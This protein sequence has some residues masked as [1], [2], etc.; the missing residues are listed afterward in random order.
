VLCSVIAI[1][2]FALGWIAFG[3]YI[4]YWAFLIAKHTVAGLR[5]WDEK[6][7]RVI[8][9]TIKP[10]DDVGMKS[11]SNECAQFCLLVNVTY[12]GMDA[13]KTVP[14]NVS[15]PCDFEKRCEKLLFE[16]YCIGE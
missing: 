5:H 4:G 1:A 13:R 12:D 11:D 9:T 3:C 16:R 2:L 7:C 6:D 10:C 8:N 14:F 15:D